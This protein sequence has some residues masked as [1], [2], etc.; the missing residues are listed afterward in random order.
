M[1]FY[2]P[3]R[4]PPR[5]TETADG[6]EIAGDGGASACGP[7]EGIVGTTRS[8]R[9]RGDVN[10]STAQ[11]PLPWVVDVGMEG[12]GAAGGRGA[13][14]RRVWRGKTPGPRSRRSSPT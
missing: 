9:G 2:L 7:E 4:V 12:L 13:A 14:W 8:Q 10:D 6:R 1:H 3:G 11:G 5:L